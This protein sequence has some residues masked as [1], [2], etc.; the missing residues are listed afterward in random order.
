MEISKT[1]AFDA[2]HRLHKVPTTHPCFTVH[3]HR[4]GVKVMLQAFDP[5]ES[6]IKSDMLLDYHNFK[7]LKQHLDDL[8]DHSLLVA[9]SDVDLLKALDTVKEAF[10]TSVGFPFKKVAILDIPETSAEDLAILLRH[11]FTQ[12]L[13]KLKYEK[14]LIGE[15]V[16]PLMIA[17]EVS[18]TPNTYAR[19]S[20][21]HLW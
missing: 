14:K 12:A 21:E 4:Y 2:A 18:E 6:N 17:V 5:Y 19:T 3:G 1:F 13:R 10:K 9:Q 11:D 20:F 15:T 8:F 16:E 7:V